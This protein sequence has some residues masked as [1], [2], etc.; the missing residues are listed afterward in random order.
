ML[1]AQ[2]T[3]K[4]IDYATNLAYP[5]TVRLIGANYLNRAQGLSFPANADKVLS[6]AIS[7]EDDPNIRMALVI[8]LGKTKTED[9]MQ[10]L[11]NQLNIEPDYRVKCNII[12]ALSNFDYNQVYASIFVAVKDKSLPVA[13]TAAN[14]FVQNGN[15]RGGSQYWKATRDT[16]HW[17][18]EL[19]LY[20]AANKH[21]PFY[22]SES[23]KAINWELK[24]RIQQSNNPYEKAEALRALGEYG[25]N[26]KYIRD[27][28]FLSDKPIIRTAGVEALA[29]ICNKRTEDFRKFFNISY[30]RVRKELS[31]YLLEAIVNGDA[32]MT[33][34]AAKALRRPES[35][36]KGTLDSLHLLDIALKK[37][38][39]PQEIETYNELNKTI[40]YLK[41]ADEPKPLTPEFNHPIDFRV[42]SSIEKNSKINIQTTKGD[43][44]LE[45]LPESAPGTVA[46]FI[47]LMKIDHFTGKTIHRVV[48]NFVMQG[49]CP[50]GDGYG[51]LDYSI[52][53]ELPN[54]HYAS[55]GYVGMASAGNHTECTQFFITHSPTPHLDGNYTIFAKVFEGMDIVHEIEIG[56]II[57]KVE[58]Q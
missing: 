54:L 11:I 18:V 45:L 55:E 5:P 16:L 40:A 51:S 15:A 28:S 32:G 8:G 52:R 10:K 44:K 42:L 20:K 21:L 46:N 33:Y 13:L 6:D 25:W 47:Q 24:Q 22:F 1:S 34:E 14:Y 27:N 12:R 38:S 58:I 3:E 56:D 31:N 9:A 50:R 37:L 36:F 30:R 48:P 2:G 41:G 29:Q 43:I 4:M 7:K 26:Y 35:F 23:I 39:L 49:G 53:S 57:E 17:Q 19:A